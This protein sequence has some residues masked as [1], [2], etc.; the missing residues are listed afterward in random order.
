MDQFMKDS[1]EMVKN[2]DKEYINGVKV[3]N[4]TENGLII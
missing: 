3:V 1:L 2:M 4:M